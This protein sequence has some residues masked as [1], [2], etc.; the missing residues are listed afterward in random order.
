MACCTLALGVVAPRR[1]PSICLAISGGW[2]F[3]RGVNRLDLRHASQRALE[4]SMLT[5][6]FVRVIGSFR[7][8][9]CF[10]FGQ[11]TRRWWRSVAPGRT[12]ASRSHLVVFAPWVP[13]RAPPT[14]DSERCSRPDLCRHFDLCKR[15]TPERHSRPCRG[16]HCDP[17]NNRDLGWARQ[18]PGSWSVRVLRSPRPPRNSTEQRRFRLRLGRK[19]T[20]PLARALTAH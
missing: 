16:S 10:D 14:S 17:C 18:A 1:S 6:F 4:R 20:S 13:W 11:G 19:Q 15:A 2:G 3:V 12:L 8:V 5:P 7:Q 9:V